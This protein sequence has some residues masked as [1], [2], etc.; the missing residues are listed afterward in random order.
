MSE[1]RDLL[2]REA[3]SVAEDDSW[4]QG[5]LRK[6]ERRRHRRR[7]L[8]SALALL[9]AASGLAVAVRA[10]TPQR[11]RPASDGPPNYEM[12]ARVSLPDEQS[13]DAA[14]PGGRDSV[15]IEVEVRWDPARWPGVHRCTWEVLDEAGNVVSTR[16]G[17]FVAHRPERGHQS[18]RTKMLD[19]KGKPASARAG[20]EPPRLDTPGIADL[21]P[22][23]TGEGS[24]PEAEWR[25]ILAELEA[26]VEAWAERFHIKQ[27]S[28]DQLA[29]N[30]WALKSALLPGHGSEHH[31]EIRELGMRLGTLCRLLPQNHEFR[32]GEFCD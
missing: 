1:I 24:P 17:L 20:C 26:R 19:L 16:T 14:G 18:S 12:E 21:G 27:M 3:V 22:M 32:G 2:E 23:P 11:V 28:P 10:F 25:A 7:V 4:L 6:V 8:T 30:M 31:L 9:M 5:T 29:G 13:S 15:W